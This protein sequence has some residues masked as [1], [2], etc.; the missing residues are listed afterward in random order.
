MHICHVIYRFDVGGMENG[1]VN[2][3]N[4]MPE[5]SVQHSIIALT[6]KTDFSKRIK[7]NNVKIYELNKRTGNDFN[8]FYR[9]YKLLRL[10]KPDIVH[11]RNHPS[12]EVPFIAKLARV[13]ACIHGEH[14]RDVH[15][16]DGS[17]KKY[18]LL[19]KLI[20]PF[21]NH[22]ICVSQDLENWLT[23]QIG[24]PAQKISQIYNGVDSIKFSPAHNSPA[25]RALSGFGD[26]D[27]IIG[28]VGRMEEVKGHIYLVKGYVK[29]LQEHPDFKGKIKL[30]I[31][32]DGTC[33]KECLD[34]LSDAGHEE[35]A[36]L[37]G[38]VENVQEL[39]PAID[40]FVLPS[41]AEGISN[42]ILEAMSCGL[43]VIA[44]AVGGN[45]EL[46]IDGH[47]GKLIPA[48][49]IDAMAHA[50]YMYVSN[51]DLRKTQGENSRKQ[52]EKQY[53]MAAM[54]RQYLDVYERFN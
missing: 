30:V 35:N 31:L 37:P 19:K 50:L 4:H 54:V 16:L 33:K 27:I 11:S 1:I 6:Y 9:L 22:Y 36:C 32:G 49:D 51:P 42:T 13:N 17:N 2:L 39:L 28:A 14:G 47:T 8:A 29:L 53:S 18:R 46:L 20:N 34:I 44:T 7:R 15:D 48:K 24:I 5:D 40:I 45:T 21:V 3:I 10:I 23:K 52:I 43:P 25:L 41:L 38:S 26:D 12:T